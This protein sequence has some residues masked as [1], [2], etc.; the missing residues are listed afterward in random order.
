MEEALALLRG[1]ETDI[2]EKNDD[3]NVVVFEVPLA[4]SPAGP[5]CSAQSSTNRGKR[6]CCCLSESGFGAARNEGDPFLLS[7]ILIFI[8]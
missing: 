4:T 3:G 1:S 6:C 8:V 5:P 7:P 2:G